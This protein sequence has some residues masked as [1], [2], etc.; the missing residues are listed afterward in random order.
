MEHTTVTSRQ[1]VHN[2][3]AAKRM[4]RQCPVFITDRGKPAFA[5]LSIEAYRR[6]ANPGGQSI[7]DL[8]AMPEAEDLAFDIKPIKLGLRELEV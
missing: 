1:F 8:L 4:A 2:V 5:L 3:S 6:M 7:V